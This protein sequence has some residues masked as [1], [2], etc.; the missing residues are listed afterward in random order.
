MI[1]ASLRPEGPR[2]TEAKFRVGDRADFEHGL[3]ALGAAP[4]PREDE[5]N[6]LFD[7]GSGSFRR[8]GRALRVRTV[9]GGGLVTFK[10]EARFERGVKSRLELETAVADPVVF[11]AIL[12]ALG[13]APLFVYEKRR[14]PW[15][16]PEA[17]RPLV[18]VDE[19]PLG[20][21]AEIEGDEAAVRAVAAELGVEESAFLP[22]SYAA[23]WE[24]ARRADP[25]L[26]RDMTWSAGD[27]P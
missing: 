2:E 11:E 9:A 14:T 3:R 21:F 10:G 16:F 8:S 20:L 27:A 18:V 5:R 22:D 24:K 19:T 25:S 6:I 23:L 4:G 26:P 15:R 17:D 7:D 13:F 1:D 12:R